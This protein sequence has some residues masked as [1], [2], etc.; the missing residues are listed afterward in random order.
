MANS[1]DGN[2]GS[3]ETKLKWTQNE[4]KKTENLRNRTN[5]IDKCRA[6]TD[7]VKSTEIT[8]EKQKN[9]RK[10]RMKNRERWKSKTKK[11]I[12]SPSSLLRAAFH[13]NNKKFGERKM[14]YFCFHRFIF[15]LRLIFNRFFCCFLLFSTYF[16]EGRNRYVARSSPFQT[17]N[18]I[19][20]INIFGSAIVFHSDSITPSSFTYNLNWIFFCVSFCLFSVC[21]L[22]FIL[23]FWC[24]VNAS[25]V[26]I[27]FYL[28][29]STRHLAI[30]VFVF[31]IISL[32]RSSFAFQLRE[33]ATCASSECQTL[34]SVLDRFLFRPN[35]INFNF[36]AVSYSWLSTDV[37]HSPNNSFVS[38]NKTM[39]RS[40]RIENIY[41]ENSKRVHKQNTRKSVYLFLSFAFVFFFSS[42]LLVYGHAEHQKKRNSHMKFRPKK[43]NENKI[44]LNT[45]RSL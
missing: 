38:P 1:S 18:R 9:K 36:I 19:A 22:Y 13:S 41:T 45:K 17:I 35:V 5:R 37:T 23:Y 3:D 43:I 6:C 16:W 25:F 40:K 32:S 7:E 42:S 14:K 11:C 2:D 21:R 12:R 34:F 28:L 15:A 8:N 27:N 10:K 29:I 26:A 31:G 20:A 39:R 33:S 4:A 30:F 24:R 44:E